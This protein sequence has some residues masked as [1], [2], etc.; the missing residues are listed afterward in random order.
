MLELG[1]KELEEGDASSR[2]FRF[3]SRER[4]KQEKR[5]ESDFFRL[6][7]FPSRSFVALR[8][9]TS[10]ERQPATPLF[11]SPTLPAHCSL[12]DPQSKP[13]ARLRGRVPS[14]N[15]AGAP[16]PEEEEEEEDEEVD[17][18][19]L[20]RLR[21][22]TRMRLFKTA[23][24]LQSSPTS[25]AS[26]PR[27]RRSCPFDLRKGGLSSRTS[28]KEMENKRKRRRGE[29]EIRRRSKKKHSDNEF[30]KLDPCRRPAKRLSLAL[31]LS[32]SFF[33]R[34]IPRD[35]ET[36]P[37]TKTGPPSTCGLRSASRCPCLSVAKER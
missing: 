10:L 36:S 3:P 26:W 20:L 25:P 6:R 23:L 7:R 9:R 18:R 30:E 13:N 15:A 21:R 28:G 24:L 17:E 1:R 34:S 27:P 5:K 2:C 14:C 35:L 33:A 12:V 16:T 29:A 32:L 4:R 19:W 8:T 11:L 31:S 22:R 37:L